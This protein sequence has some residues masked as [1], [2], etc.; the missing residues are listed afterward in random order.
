MHFISRMN[1]NLYYHFLLLLPALRHVNTRFD[2][3][4]LILLKALP[5][6]V[7]GLLLTVHELKD[8][9]ILT[10]DHAFLDHKVKVNQFLPVF[11][12][13]QQ[14]WQGFYLFSLDQFPGCRAS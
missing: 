5:N 12:T 14:H 8:R 13:K 1:V 7:P 10:T 3:N 2:N 9:Q 4:I 6:D 11:L